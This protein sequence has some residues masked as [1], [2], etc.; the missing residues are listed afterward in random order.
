[1]IL[2]VTLAAVVAFV[3]GAFLLGFGRGEKKELT[4][5]DVAAE[6]AGAVA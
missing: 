5:E 4:E 2:Q 3:V 1:M 6:R